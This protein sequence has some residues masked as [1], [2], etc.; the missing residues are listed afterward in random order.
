MPLTIKQVASGQREEDIPND[1]P[2]RTARLI[3]HLCSSPLPVLSVRDRDGEPVNIIDPHDLDP[4]RSVDVVVGYASRYLESS[5]L[6]SGGGCC[7]PATFSPEQLAAAIGYSQSELAGAPLV[8][9][10][11]ADALA[12]GLTDVVVS[13]KPQYVEAMSNW[14]DPLY[15]RIVESLPPDAKPSDFITSV[16]ISAHK[17]R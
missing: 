2:M 9:E 17:P 7:G 13:P 11:R 12:A 10:L 8:D 1:E 3:E 14:E 4:R 6:S 15:R 5:T 16:D